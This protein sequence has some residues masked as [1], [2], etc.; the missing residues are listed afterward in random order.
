MIEKIDAEAYHVKFKK[1][2]NKEIKTLFQ[3][4]EAKNAEINKK[5]QFENLDSFKVPDHLKI[6]PVPY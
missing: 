4:R 1:Y 2:N 6:M 5:I 3:L